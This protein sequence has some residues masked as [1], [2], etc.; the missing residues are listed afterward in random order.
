MQTAIVTIDIPSPIYLHIDGVETH[1]L[2]DST[3]SHRRSKNPPSLV[4]ISTMLV[5]IGCIWLVQATNPNFSTNAKH[6]LR[7][8]VFSFVFTLVVLLLIRNDCADV[9]TSKKSFFCQEHV[10]MA[11]VDLFASN[12]HIRRVIL[13]GHGESARIAACLATNDYWW[14]KHECDVTIIG[15]IVIN[16]IYSDKRLTK[17]ELEKR[18]GTRNTY[19]DEFPVYNIRDT[20]TCPF[21]II[22]DETNTHTTPHSFDLHYT[23]RH[24]GVFSTIRYT[25]KIEE[26]ASFVSEFQDIISVQHPIETVIRS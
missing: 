12:P 2:A 8:F 7:M 1:N 19:V 11:L 15:C 6:F 26:I 23:L 24:A 10:M 5:C 9:S 21:L 4:E 18:F 3:R 16:G 17:H 22:D 20:E 14:K 13:V 25:N